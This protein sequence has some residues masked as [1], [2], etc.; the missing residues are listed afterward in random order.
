LPRLN[1]DLLD[2]FLG[3]VNSNLGS[4]RPVWSGEACVGVAIAS[5]GY[6]GKYQIGLPITGLGDV[7]KDIMVFHAGTKPGSEPGQ[8]L[9]N[10]GR[11][12]TVV[13]SG[14]TLADAREKVYDNIS[15]I[16]FEGCHYRKDIALVDGS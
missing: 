8:V 9:T 2:L 15:R 12:L 4:V 14:K 13:G 1:S 16:R 5:G 3:V 6:P 7:D 10:G 11:V